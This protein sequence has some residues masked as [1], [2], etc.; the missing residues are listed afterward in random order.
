MLALIVYRKPSFLD[1]LS[2]KLWSSQ[3][4][5]WFMQ[6]RIDA[7]K[8]QDLYEVW[9]RDLTIPVRCSN[10]L[11]YEATDVGSW[12][13]FFEVLN[14]SGFYT[15]LHKIN[16]IHNCKDH[17]LLD[18]TSAVQYKKYF[19]YYHLPWW[20]MLT[21][22]AQVIFRVK[23]NPLNS[24]N[25]SQQF[26]DSDSNYTTSKILTIGTKQTHL[27]GFKV[28]PQIVFKVLTK[29]KK[30]KRPVLLINFH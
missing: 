16:C 27:A 28:S 7:W 21:S 24:D 11:S 5:T 26:T 12:S 2:S 25:P 19:I 20:F 22:W 18:F 23:K 17:S 3:L 30:G 15:Q 9:T 14:F 6:L 10:Q 8:I 29:E 4:W 13:F 1:D